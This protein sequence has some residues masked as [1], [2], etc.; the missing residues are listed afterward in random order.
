MDHFA[1]RIRFESWFER[2]RGLTFLFQGDEEEAQ[3]CL[4]TAVESDRSGEKLWAALALA[5][6]FI[7]RGDLD[8]AAPQVE[9]ALALDTEPRL[10]VA[11]L[12][13]AVVQWLR[14]D[15]KEALEALDEAR[16]LDRYAADAEDL[17]YD[18][19]W[20]DKAL[21]AVVEM[22]AARSPR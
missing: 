2:L 8:E 20:R 3:A 11:V 16:W 15:K 1:Y 7:E 5:H 12:S 6:F 13:H 10:P 19:F 22:A 14:G 17:K 21:A 18:H 9:R 4:L